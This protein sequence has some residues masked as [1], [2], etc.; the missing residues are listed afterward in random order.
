MTAATIKKQMEG[1]LPLL[2][3][4]QQVLVLEMIKSFLHVD[5][6][7]RITKAQY[8]KEI[9]AAI[10]EVEKGNFVTHKSALKEL[11]KW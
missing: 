9:E 10:A 11:E 4:K 7:K 2:T 8:N 5:T 6:N 1:Y 3:N